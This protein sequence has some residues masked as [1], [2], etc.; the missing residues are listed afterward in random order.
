MSFENSM[1]ARTL[2]ALVKAV[3]KH[4]KWFV[5]P[6]LLLSAL[7]VLYAG[8]HLRLDMN[9]DNLVSPRVRYHQLFLQF[10]QEFP[11]L[12]QHV[13][14]VESGEWWRSRRFIERLATHL[15]TQT[16]LFTDVFYKVDLNSLGPKG[17]LLASP[18]ELEHM[19]QA[20]E[21][22]APILRDFTQTTN[23]NSLFGLLN[24]QF[25]SAGGGAT[26]RGEALV[27]TLPFLERMVVDANRSLSESVP[28]PAPGIGP[29]FGGGTNAEA[30]IYLTYDKGRML[31]LTVR[32]RSKAVVEQG[33]EQ[34]RSDLLQTQQEVPGVNAGLTGGL[35]LNYDEMRQSKHDS[36]VASVTALVLCSLIFVVAY[37]EVS[38]PLKAALCL[39]IGCGYTLG[40]AALAV[41]HLN[42]MSVSFAP[43]LIGLA[44]DYGVHFMSRYEE[45]M[46]HRRPMAEALY[47]ATVYTGQGIVVGC[48]T[49]G[50]AFLAMA[51]TG[52]RGVR[53]VGIICGGGLLLCLVPMMTTLP[54]LLMRG[55]QNQR[56]YEIGP[57][58][59]AR[60]RLEQV[61]LQRPKL[62]VGLTL[63]V[64]VVACGFAGR[65]YFDY[66]LLRLQS[67]NLASVRYEHKLSQSAGRSVISGAVIPDS[68]PQAR[69]YEE[70]LRA[71]PSVSRVETVAQ[72]LTGDQEKKL[73][74]VRALQRDLA[75]IRVAP[76][77]RGP[78]QV[79][80]LNAT[81]WSLGGYLAWAADVA[82]TRDPALASQMRALRG[83]LS[84]FRK[85]LL[86]GRPQIPLQLSRYQ[87]ALFTELS[88]S[89]SALQHQDASG[90]LR[91]QDL[92]PVLRAQFVGVTGKYLL[93]VYPKRDIWQH[94]NQ[95]EFIQ[96]LAGV[97]PAE[98]ITGPPIQM[99][100][101]TALL[102][103]SY[104][105][106]A[107]Y[108]LGAIVLMLWLHFR[109]PG[110]VGLALL[111]VAIGSLWLFGYMGA[112]GLSLNPANIMTLPLVLGIGV[113]N[114]IQILNR[115][116][117]EQHPAIF[118]RS[119]GKAVLV[120]GLTAMT[121]F[122][123]L[124]LAKY[125]GMRSL[126]EVMS[127]GIAACMLAAL[128]I[129]PAL[130]SLLLRQSQAR[131]FLQRHLHLRL[132]WH[133]T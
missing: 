62:A 68:A 18:T 49:M 32:P 74:L 61:W 93:R 71:L 24:A 59:E 43:M 10:Q 31:L 2:R 55:R 28:P 133:R 72:Y 110:L 53:E 128:I 83:R 117:E 100:E 125:Q 70:K 119:T 103:K 51:L 58:G 36:E 23:L 9:R 8:H 25:R 30:Q 86:S 112:L 66:N 121:G 52:F 120:S 33:I 113:T 123:T 29:L 130:L 95:G 17:L 57:A 92:P 19:R 64:S 104:E 111:P 82:Q 126:G 12:D 54:A 42:I 129:L 122:G 115:F 127:A 87:V 89:L 118:A 39:L 13:V 21:Q 108:A 15:E 46:R 114:G 94:A 5:Y 16:N 67:Q 14:V 37:R 98:K 47:R 106:A 124:L 63:L 96:Q 109:S 56:D 91:A 73:Q 78:V 76:C 48:L 1:L 132:G 102:K 84:E 6:Q 7:C 20:V 45:E 34:L 35:V 44:I 65:V 41:G 77:D 97:I 79:D 99:Y 27:G 85:T 40:F 101:S 38:R 107:W 3:C 26:N 69:E 4:P 22:Y 105:Q 80:E 131:P 50:A 60:L 116:A 75:G 88:R 81:L 90:P 11:G